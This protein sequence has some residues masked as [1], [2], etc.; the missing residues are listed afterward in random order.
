MKYF[1]YFNR[2]VMI[3]FANHKRPVILEQCFPKHPFIA[4]RRAFWR[5]MYTVKLNVK[6]YLEEDKEISKKGAS[7]W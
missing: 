7:V 2:Y 6:A 1:V 5:R 4:K 3:P